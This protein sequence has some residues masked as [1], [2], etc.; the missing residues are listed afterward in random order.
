M[1]ASQRP[2]RQVPP[3]T[4][5]TQVKDALEHLY[6]FAYLQRHPLAQE[7][8]PAAQ[9]SAEIASQRLR[10]ELVAAIETLN[11][12]E[13]VP[14]RAAPARLYNVL[15]LRYIEGL[16]VRATAHELGI[17]YR[18]AL[19][20]LRHGEES[21]A[22]VLWA[23]RA[24]SPE[25]EVAQLS[26]FE[27]EMARL[28]HHP[29]LTDI[30]A[31]LERAQEDVRSQATQRDVSL[32]VERPDKPAIISTNPVVAEQ[33]LVNGLSHV[34]GQAQPGVLYLALTTQENQVNL[35]LRYFAEAGAANI[36]IAHPLVAQLADR[37]G[38]ILQQRDDANGARVVVLQMK[39]Y[40]P[41][42][43]VIDDNEGLVN[44]MKRYL[45]DRACR[46]IAATN[47]QE[48]LRLAQELL[49]DAIVLDVMMPEMAGWEALQ[50][51]R[52]DSR[53]ANIPV[54]ICTVVTNPD[55]A[56]SLGASLFLPKPIR[57]DDVLNAL[58]QVGVI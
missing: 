37:L 4:F 43:L 18:Q 7:G 13:A 8:G 30:C 2:Q 33:V 22:V 20:D 17:S 56:Y 52:N 47:G 10:Q 14:F 9:P 23:R 5:V 51:L 21:A 53:T 45:T 28:E 31:L 48:G 54:I 44:L 26:S 36:P 24:A 29:R 15:T 3:Q 16:T 40:G 34:I 25:Y 55:L 27:A 6:D 49:P 11:P 46:V 58:R 41:A 50:R 1:S 42:I 32:R 12:G 39:A 19:R 38:W 57:R 35:T